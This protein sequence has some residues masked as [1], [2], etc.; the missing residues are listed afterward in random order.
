MTKFEK[1]KKE[2][3]GVA[4]GVDLWIDGTQFFYIDVDADIIQGYRHVTA[5]CGCCSEIVDYEPDLSYELE[6]MDD[7]DFSD[8]IDELI[9][10]K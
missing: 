1:I 5:A 8:L 4:G 9:K 3:A 10:L 2:F 7:M 6:Y